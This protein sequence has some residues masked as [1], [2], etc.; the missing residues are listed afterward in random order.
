MSST[1]NEI[2]KDLA[3]D[4]AYEMLQQFKS[5]VRDKLRDYSNVWNHPIV[6]DSNDYNKIEKLAIQIF[7]KELLINPN[8]LGN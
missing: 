6:D 2:F 4:L 8:Q 5:D 7:A 1:V 3:D